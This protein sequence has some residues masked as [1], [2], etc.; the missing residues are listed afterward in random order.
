MLRKRA[1][2]LLNFFLSQYLCIDHIYPEFQVFN[3]F[4]TET[5]VP[6]M[7]M[8]ALENSHPVLSTFSL[9]VSGSSVEEHIPL[10]QDESGSYP[11]E[12]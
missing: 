1:Q 2:L 3:Y 12:C 8:D 9:G 11:V 5:F 7:G 4:C 10:H 6:A